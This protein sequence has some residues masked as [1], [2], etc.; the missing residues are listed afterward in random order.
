MI[1]EDFRV[2]LIEVN[3]NP[4]LGI[5]NDYIRGLLPKMLND[6]MS[7]TIDS[8]FTPE[9]KISNQE[10]GFELIYSQP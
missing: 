5:P 1:D 10:N 7:I 8:L 2:Y 3:T 9:L 6:M 4:Y